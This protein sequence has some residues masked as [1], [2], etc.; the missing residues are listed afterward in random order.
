MAVELKLRWRMA[1]RECDCT[2]CWI[3]VRRL[4]WKSMFLYCGLSAGRPQCG[5]V[6]RVFAQSSGLCRMEE[7]VYAV[8]GIDKKK[9]D[10]L[11]SLLFQQYHREKR[12]LR[13]GITLQSVDAVVY[14]CGI[15]FDSIY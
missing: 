13:S 4:A 2:F 11:H 5:N 3:S 9:N 7:T 15:D 8:S 14:T 1:L 6:E 12:R 10:R